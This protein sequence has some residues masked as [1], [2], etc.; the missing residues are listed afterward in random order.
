MKTL[1][2]RIGNFMFHHRNRI[3]PLF[4]VVGVVL[5]RPTFPGGSYTKDAWLDAA[6]LLVCMIGQALRVV[7]IGFEYIKRGG[8]NEQI[9]AD[10]LVQG[11]MFAHSRNPLYLGNILM[12]FGLVMI[13]NSPLAYAIGY[14]AVVF[15][16]YCI[17]MAEEQFLR[18]K[19]GAAYDDYCRRVNRLWPDLRGFSNS[20]K[21]MKFNWSRVIVKE[22]STTFAWMISAVLLRAWCLYYVLGRTVAWPEI[23]KLL[24]LLLPIALSYLV[25]RHLKTSRRLLAERPV[26]ETA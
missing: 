21:D 20:V 18:G 12:F 19:F 11:G 10:K 16:Y 17:I 26:V 15:T 22:Y 2:V 24:L 7:T 8:K 1:L 3:F 13:L 14:P 5:A 25:V 9:W 6:G 4:M 23:Y